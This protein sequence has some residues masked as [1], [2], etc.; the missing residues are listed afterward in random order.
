MPSGGVYKTNPAHTA[1]NETLNSS[2]LFCS[3]EL[4]MQTTLKAVTP[5]A[6]MASFFCVARG[7]GVS[8]ASV[9]GDA[10]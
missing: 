8:E 5:F 9:G 10:L 7:F 2:P 4:K 3:D 6:G 1:Q